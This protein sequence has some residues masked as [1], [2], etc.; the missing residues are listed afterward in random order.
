MIARLFCLAFLAACTGLPGAGPRPGAITAPPADAAYMLIPL[1]PQIAA[2]LGAP[3]ADSAS[4]FPRAPRSNVQMAAPGDR[5]SIQIWE[6]APD[7]LFAAS[8]SKRTQIEAT[9]DAQSRIFMPYAGQISVAGLRP[10][11]I[12]DAIAAALTGQTIDPQVQV[13]FAE[14]APPLVTV[15]GALRNPGQFALPPAGLDLMGALALAG[16]PL[17]P[18][19]E[20]A[21]TLI[22]GNQRYPGRLDPLQQ[23][24]DAGPW[25]QPGDHVI[26]RHD[27]R[28]YTSFGAIGRPARQVFAS[29]TVTLAEALAETGGLNDQRAAAQA[30]FLYRRETGARLA[31]AGLDAPPG[32]IAVI[33]HLDLRQ[34]DGFF[35]ASGFAM[36]DKDILYVG[37]AAATELGKFTGAL[38]P[39]LGATAALRGAD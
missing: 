20:N 17:A 32:P 5:L 23:G 2:S 19:H 8:G 25:L 28:S 3:H 38:L 35:A 36:R 10:D 34:P 1:T 22:R 7:P 27:P 13:A 18:A 24:Q 4:H 11:Q 37:T 14:K 6:A 16:G 39:G 26:L 33:Y 29:P 31:A 15:S 9:V 12:R 30:V 21:V